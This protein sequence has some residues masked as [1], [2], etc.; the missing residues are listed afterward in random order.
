MTAPKIIKLE[1]VVINRIAAGEVIQRPANAIKEM[2]E[3]C[4]DAKSKSI[5]VTVKN[6]G[7]KLI[8]VQDDGCGIRKEDM[9]IVCE[10][11]TTSK[12]SSFGDLK[13]ISTHGFRGEALA[14]ISH[15]AHLTI[16]TKTADSKCA[17]KAKYEDGK[18]VPLNPGGKA[19][20]KP[21]AGNKGTQI[22]VEDLFYNVS[23]RRKALKNGNEEHSK[24]YDVISKY[25]IHNPSISF[26]L[27]KQGVNNAD[28]RTSINSTTLDAIK[29]IYGPVVSKELL[30]ISLEDAQLGFKL[31][32]H[33]SNA[34]YSVKKCIFLLF[35]NHRLVD[36][37]SLKKAIEFVY[38]NYLPKDG[39]PF[40]YLS[41]EI[42]PG[43]VDVNVHPTKHE[44]KFLHE[45]LILEKIQKGIEE[46]LLGSNESRRFYTQSLLPKVITVGLENP[47]SEALADKPT[48]SSAP[49]PVYDHQYVRTDAKE[50]KLQAFF[51]P[52]SSK[53]S[54]KEETNNSLT[55]S[56]N[57]EDFQNENKE[58]KLENSKNNCAVKKNTSVNAPM[59]YDSKLTSITNLCTKIDEEE[60]SGLKNILEEHKYVGCANKSLALIQHGTMLYL[61]N[62]K[63]VSQEMFYQ[64]LI[65][66]F[67]HFGFLRLSSPAPV[68]DLVMLALDSP[69][70]GW[71]PSDGVKE[72]LAEYVKNLLIGKSAMLLEYF[73][74]EIN[75]EGEL[76]ALPILLPKYIPNWN[77]LPML[78]LRLSTEVDWSDE[79]NCFETFAKECSHFYAFR[80][81][82]VGL[83]EEEDEEST[84]KW[85]GNVEHLLFPAVRSYLVPP[86]SLSSDGSFLEIANLN[87]LYKVFERC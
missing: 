32:G 49:K 6:G 27:K 54:E 38:Q 7:L 2:I 52:S 21:V 8:Q 25:A 3:N 5:Q 59:R 44:V 40:L 80:P 33:I 42:T 23:I 30:K 12:L 4:I 26:T 50:R 46:K 66:Q 51:S 14:S 71:E 22:T 13:S 35:I 62:I 70:S 10:R 18:M 31:D 79:Q 56:E 69:D 24:I 61:V 57:E 29:T 78:L 11:F 74:F 58:N 37:T 64:I 65:F 67:S 28:V 63:K 53:V 76:L 82:P 87:D 19:E 68:F 16:T 86:K 77:G 17:F 15:V 83:D 85:K 47:V 60:H 72:E 81:D 34:N 1:E 45:D 20:P 48:T 75:D 39:H 84:E 43:N 55:L 36:S 73:S 41:L 9:D